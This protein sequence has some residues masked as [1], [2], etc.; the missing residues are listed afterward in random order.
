MDSTYM[1]RIDL[2]IELLWE[3]LI[4][5]DKWARELQGLPVFARTVLAWQKPAT[6]LSHVGPGDVNQVLRLGWQVLYLCFSQL[7]SPG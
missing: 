3:S 2:N 6:L 7:S 5:L 4:W 1:I